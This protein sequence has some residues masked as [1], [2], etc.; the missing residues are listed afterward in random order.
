MSE[1]QQSDNTCTERDY[2]A[3]F[4]GPYGGAVY[5]AGRGLPITLRLY[6]NNIRREGSYIFD[7]SLR[8]LGEEF[9]DHAPVGILVENR[10]SF[11]SSFPNGYFIEAGPCETSLYFLWTIPSDFYMIDTDVRLTANGGLPRSS[12]LPLLARS[13][14]FRILAN[15]NAS[16]TTTEPEKTS[17]PSNSTTV[18]R[19]TAVSTGASPTPSG[20]S[21]GVTESKL[22]TGP[23]AG[24]G[25]GVGV[26]AVLIALGLFYIW[27]RRSKPARSR[28][29]PE[30][31]P[32]EKA[33]LDGNPPQRTPGEIDGNERHEADGT[34]IQPP[35]QEPVE[36]EAER[37]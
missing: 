32:Y 14:V 13:S 27:R 36:L 8:S 17:G 20:L 37:M 11:N 4:K 2:K 33:E 5:R 10:I 9:I 15:D 26:A 7:I 28:E 35:Q 21:P 29:I 25:A 1:G 34:E 22:S 24:I 31:R 12:T 19:N 30:A 16:S 18:T 6:D 3:V 23:K